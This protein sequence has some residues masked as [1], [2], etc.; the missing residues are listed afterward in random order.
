MCLDRVIPVFMFGNHYQIH[1]E[2]KFVAFIYF[3]FLSNFVFDKFLIKTS[4]GKQP[5]ASNGSEIVF[6]KPYQIKVSH[7]IFVVVNSNII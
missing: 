6:S 1:T 7:N 4:I 3:F 5:K 2:Y